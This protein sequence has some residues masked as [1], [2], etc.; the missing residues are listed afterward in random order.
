[1]VN[2]RSFILT[3]FHKFKLPFVLTYD[4]R[5]RRSLGVRKS[6][7]FSRLNQ[8]LYVLTFDSSA[9]R[10]TGRCNKC[11]AI[12][13]VTLDCPFRGPGQ[14][15]D[16][17]KFKKPGQVQT[18]GQSH[19]EVCY[20]FQDDKCKYGAKCSRKHVCVGCGGHKVQ[21]LYQMQQV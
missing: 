12:D 16:L 3:M 1:M 10:S 13:H 15:N 7:R 6:L 18:Q 21:D 11:A 8:E 2:Y 5:H 19:N 20:R 4:T 17:S 9:L 14:A